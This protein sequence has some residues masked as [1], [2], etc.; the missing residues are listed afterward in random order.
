MLEAPETATEITDGALVPFEATDVSVEPGGLDIPSLLEIDTLPEDQQ[1]SIRRLQL[2]F[3]DDD[4]DDTV[5]T[6]DLERGLADQEAFTQAE[7]DHF[8]SVKDLFL[9]RAVSPANAAIE[10]PVPGTEVA[11]FDVGPVG[12]ET[13][14]TT[15]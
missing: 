3:D 2:K 12:L 6:D 13:I 5:T 7:L 1:R 15:V 8:A 4:D 14:T 10:I 11:S 9:Y